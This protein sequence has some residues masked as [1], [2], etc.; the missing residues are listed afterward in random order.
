MVAGGCAGVGFAAA[1]LL[2]AEG[3]RVFISGHAQQELDAAVTRMGGCV[4]GL[5]GHPG[6]LGDIDHVLSTIRRCVGQLDVLV[7]DACAEERLLLD[8]VTEAAFDRSFGVNV[9]GLLFT[10]QTALPLLNDGASIV[11]LGVDG[12]ERDCAGLSVS[13][14]TQA[15]VREFARAW[16][17]ELTHRGIR[18]S[19]VPACAVDHGAFAAALI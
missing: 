9:R 10:V 5:R 7:V 11:L 13:H 6:D 16:S 17:A 2:V 19:V 3:A 14:A 12:G 18:V 1:R 4:M 15:V 8:Q